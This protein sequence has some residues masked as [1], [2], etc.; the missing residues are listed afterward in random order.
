MKGLTK[1]KGLG[2]TSALHHTQGF[3]G[4]GKILSVAATSPVDVS[5]DGNT[6]NFDPQV[7]LLLARQRSELFGAN[8]RLVR[9]DIQI[10]VSFA[11]FWSG[12][13]ESNPKLRISNALMAQ[14]IANARGP[15][16]SRIEML[17]RQSR[18]NLFVEPLSDT[19]TIR[20]SKPRSEVWETQQFV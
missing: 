12:R 5:L 7:S 9:K 2:S 4:H 11:A 19:S 10:N 17:I 13:W 14:G 1:G 6:E 20:P 18:S 16:R 15:K 8:P 3:A